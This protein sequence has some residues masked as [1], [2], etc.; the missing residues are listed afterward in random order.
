M[1]C[2]VGMEMD[3]KM[4]MDM[5]MEMRQQ[6]AEFEQSV[7]SATRNTTAQIIRCSPR[8]CVATASAA[9]ASPGYRMANV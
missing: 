9:A 4:D 6:A 2:L 7:Q 8:Q 1:R 3:M 5:G